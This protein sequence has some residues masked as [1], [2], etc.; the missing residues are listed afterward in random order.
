[1]I[2]RREM[3]TVQAGVREV[4]ELL[5]INRE[6]LLKI[7]TVDTIFILKLKIKAPRQWMGVDLTTINPHN[8]HV[9]ANS[10]PK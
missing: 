2:V 3:I 10:P 1:M 7:L 8:L 5:Y 4:E 6:L 9:V